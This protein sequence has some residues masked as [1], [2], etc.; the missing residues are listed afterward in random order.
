MISLVPFLAI[1]VQA[2]VCLWVLVKVGFIPNKSFAFTIPN[3][4]SH[5][6]PTPSQKDI[7]LVFFFSNFLDFGFFSFFLAQEKQKQKVNYPRNK[8]KTQDLKKTEIN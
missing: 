8:T 7:F 5:A 1:L 4:I 3:P 2:W 6:N